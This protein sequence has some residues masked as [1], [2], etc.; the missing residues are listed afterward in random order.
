MNTRKIFWSILCCIF[1]LF[2]AQSL[3]KAIDFAYTTHLI[4]AITDASSPYESGIATGKALRFVVL[5]IAYLILA[6]S[7]Y[8]KHFK[9]IASLKKNSQFFF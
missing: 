8:L 5:P 1:L 3:L 6:R 2:T 4:N 9:N 7:I